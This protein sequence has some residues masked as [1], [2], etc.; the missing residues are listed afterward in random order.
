[1]KI[2][3]VFLALAFTGIAFA[4]QADDALFQELGGQPGL[5]KIA[6]GPLRI[7]PSVAARVARM[8]TMHAKD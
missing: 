6:S 2:A 1:M 4:A 7:E 5:A 8:Q 3:T